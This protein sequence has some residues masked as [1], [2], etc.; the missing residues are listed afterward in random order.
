MNPV[1]YQF[2]TEEVEKL[3]ELYLD[4]R[5]SVLEETELEYVLMHCDFDSP[6]V[7][8]TKEMMAVSRAIKLEAVRPH[9]SFWTWS[10]RV[11]ACVAIALG[12]FAIF[13]PVNTNENDDSCIVYVEGKRASGEEAQ[14]IAEADVA[15]MQQFIEVVNEQQVQEEAKVEEFMNHINQSR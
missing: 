15:K 9:K 10:L 5:L 4:C 1:D 8:E 11:A 13:N 14:K 12:V 7:N 2:T 6:I 3:C